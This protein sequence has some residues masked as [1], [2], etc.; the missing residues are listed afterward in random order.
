VREVE[1]V[2]DRHH[3]VAR[4]PGIKTLSSG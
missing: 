3:P 2:A 4:L 1:G